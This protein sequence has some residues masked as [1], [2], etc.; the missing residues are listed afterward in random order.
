MHLS[1]LG[2]V[3]C[4]FSS[5]VSSGC[6]V[7]W[8]QT[9]PILVSILSS[10]RGHHLSSWSVM[11][12]W[13]QHPLFT[14]TAGNILVLSN[15]VPLCYW[16]CCRVSCVRGGLLVPFG[17]VLPFWQDKALE[18][19]APLLVLPLLSLLDPPMGGCK[20]DAK[21]R[22]MTGPLVSIKA[23]CCLCIDTCRLEGEN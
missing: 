11:T 20:V 7:G 22:A 23:D 17:K 8:L 12:W 3:C 4:A 15:Y 13:L 21:L 14:D 19:Q 16:V 6:T 9:N 2:P 18:I 5:C 10:L 1:C